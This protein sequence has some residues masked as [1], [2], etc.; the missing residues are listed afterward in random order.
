MEIILKN[1]KELNKRIISLGYSK[2]EYAQKVGVSTST[3]H[4]VLA[5]VRNASPRTA[6][7]MCDALGVN[8]DEVFEIVEKGE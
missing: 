1:S 7:N 5:K 3:V 6:K 2:K 4:A 8:F